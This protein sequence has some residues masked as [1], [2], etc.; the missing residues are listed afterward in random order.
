MNAPVTCVAVVTGGAAGI[1]RACVERLLRDGLGV[2][3][4]DSASDDAAATCRD[5]GHAQDRLQF[6][7]GDV[8]DASH[9][10]AAVERALA[11]WGRLDVLIAN[12]G[13]QTG[14]TLL[15]TSD[16]DWQRVLDV[17][18]SGVRHACRAASIQ[19][20]HYGKRTNGRRHHQKVDG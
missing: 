3:F 17:N 10:Q 11:A 4:T 20:S 9:L 8:R 13:V 7:P 19:T 15:D 14:G 1:G 6:V 18:L 2:L 16:E 12:A 5:L